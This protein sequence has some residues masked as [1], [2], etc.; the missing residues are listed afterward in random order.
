MQGVALG[1]SGGL[2]YVPIV[3]LTPEWFSERR[4]L[5]SG[6][7]YAGIGVGGEPFPEAREVS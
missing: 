5:A 2:L 3:K 6:I 4:G 1:I 7:I